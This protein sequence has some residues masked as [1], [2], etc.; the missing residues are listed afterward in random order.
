[1][2]N[3]RIVT[4]G[5]ATWACPKGLDDGCGLQVVRPGEVQ[6]DVCESSVEPRFANVSCSQ[7]GQ[8]F[9]PGNE[10]FSHCDQHRERPK[11][12]DSKAP[13]LLP[14]PFCGGDAEELWPRTIIGN[15]A[16]RCKTCGASVPCKADRAEW[17][18]RFALSAT[19]KP[20]EG[21]L[22]AGT[23]TVWRIVELER[24]LAEIKKELQNREEQI[25]EYIDTFGVEL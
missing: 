10:G 13:A 8:D 3:T 24:E 19:E 15:E 25:K 17:N 5:Y 9:G 11:E 20:R 2:K 14:C 18:R 1:M 22:H 6:C 7:C 16:V 21:A 4:D 12:K 23:P